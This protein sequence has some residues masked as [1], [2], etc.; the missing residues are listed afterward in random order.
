M[1]IFTAEEVENSGKRAIR[2]TY[3]LNQYDRIPR[4]ITLIVQQELVGYQRFPAAYEYIEETN[5]RRYPLIR[6]VAGPG[7]SVQLDNFPVT[8][9]LGPGIPD[10][11]IY[12]VQDPEL[13]PAMAQDIDPL[14]LIGVDEINPP[15]SP[16]VSTSPTNYF[17]VNRFA[18]DIIIQH[19]F[20]KTILKISVPQLTTDPSDTSNA[21]ARFAYEFNPE[22]D[23]GSVDQP[24]LR[25]VKTAEV[26]VGVTGGRLVQLMVPSLV[27]RD[28]RELDVRE[29]FNFYKIYEVDESN[30]VPP[31]GYSINP[32]SGWREVGAALLPSLEV[33]MARAYF[34]T[35]VGLTPWVGAIVDIAEFVYGVSTGRDRWGRRLTLADKV[36]M[37]LGALVSLLPILG[38]ARRLLLRR[39]GRRAQTVEELLQALRRSISSEEA[40]LLSAMEDLI[41]AGRQPPV[42]MYKKLAKLLERLP[43][44]FPSVE[45][46]L[47]TERKGFTHSK[48]QE[49]YQSYSQRIKNAG[50]SPAEPQDW[51]RLTRNKEARRIL[52]TLLGPDFARGTQKVSKQVYKNVNQIP[53]PLGLTNENIQPTVKRLYQ[54]FDKLTE[55]LNTLK[56][57]RSSGNIIT[58]SLSRQQIGRG[59]FSILKG[60]IGEILSLSI[61]IS[62]LKQEA[63]KLPG[64]RL[65]SGVKMRLME[66]GGK[67]SDSLLF[68]DNIIAVQQGNDLLILGV[69]EVKSSKR[70]PELDAQV[71]IFRWIEERITDGSELV[72][73][74]GTRIRSLNGK[75]RILRR[76]RVFT[77]NPEKANVP[78]VKLL[79]SAD[80]HIIVPR[81]RSYLGIDSSSVQVATKVKLYRMNE[82]SAEIDF[83]AGQVIAS[84]TW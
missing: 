36:V 77:F 30:T 43:S 69:F 78:R 60:N 13:I 6:V 42:D 48:L 65:I 34:D 44:D 84:S 19:P 11:E 71:Q 22:G 5:E 46:F 62:I 52:Q 31:Q 17:L 9:M 80:R 51:I 56:V 28:L 83:I 38:G 73:A 55:R 66:K 8:E 3:K 40:N 57:E 24:L 39:F 14:S 10:V 15:S 21:R 72:L 27:P 79:L 49:L 4:V 12:R 59:H 23:L 54:E 50:K 45:F 64:A 63:A 32:E 35:M 18:H 67:L 75:E 70:I 29:I 41:R 2:L 61:Q 74:P 37:G 81:G 33:E 53:R 20:T 68:T 26:E 16:L 82:T 25:I 47:N 76:E 58:Q 1:G 7:I